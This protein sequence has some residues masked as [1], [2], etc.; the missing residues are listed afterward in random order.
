MKKILVV[1]DEKNIRD[2]LKDILSLNGYKVFTAQNGKEGIEMATEELPDLIVS[3]VMMPEMNGYELI[4]NIRKM[5]KFASIP[6]IFLTAKSDIDSL[7]NGMMLGADDY[8]VKPFKAKELIN[9]IRLRIGKAH[10]LKGQQIEKE[11]KARTKKIGE[12]RDKLFEENANITSSIEYARRIQHAFLPDESLLRSNIKDCFLIYEPKQIVSGDFYWWRN[13]RGKLVVAAIDCTGHGVPGALLSIAANNLMNTVAG[14]YGLNDPSKILQ[15]L[16][17]LFHKIFKSSG[18]KGIQ[19]GMDMSVCTID[20]KSKIIEF[21]GAKRPLIHVSSKD[22]VL[23]LKGNEIRENGHARMTYVKGD[24]ISIDGQQF[25]G[26]FTKH[27]F[28]YVPGDKIYMFS[29]GFTDQF[30]GERGKKYQVSQLKELCLSVHGMSMNDQ[31]EAIKKAHES[32]R[33][34]MEQVDDIVLIGLELR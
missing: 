15:A 5:E 22:N 31:Y 17:D 29:D 7:R 23:E 26:Q 20:D 33:G 14:E 10:I 11:V 34:D 3:D 21:A 32:W 6:F 8:I 4:E 12:E 2:T 24:L 13:I 1:E 30:G 28:S 18:K 27:K 19:D 25:V 9:A 16:N